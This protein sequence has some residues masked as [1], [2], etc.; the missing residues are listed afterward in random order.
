MKNFVYVTKKE[1]TP[2]K[3]KLIELIN[4]VQDEVR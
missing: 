3:N 1:H 2:L 4:L